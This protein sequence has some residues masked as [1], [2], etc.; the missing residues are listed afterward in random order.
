MKNWLKKK[1]RKW[2]DIDTLNSELSN[3]KGEFSSHNK[4]NICDLHLL[5]DQISISHQSLKEDISHFQQSVNTLH[6][7]VENVVHIG[8][9]VRNNI[10]NREHSWAVICIE[11]KMNIVKFVELAREDGRYVLDFLKQF[12][13]GRHCI[14]APCKEM[15]YDGLFKF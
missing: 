4:R 8:T 2:L 9:D 7:T 1:L 6:K 12:E 10:N 5:Y 15:F 3:L 11:G 13:S 14:D